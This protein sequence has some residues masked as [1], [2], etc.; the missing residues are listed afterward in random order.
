MLGAIGGPESQ[1]MVVGVGEGAAATDG[2]EPRIAL[3]REDHGCCLSLRCGDRLEYRDF[4]VWEPESA[5]PEA[6]DEEAGE[7]STDHLSRG[8]C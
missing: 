7:R 2:D 1:E 5:C 3:F 6:I 4:N 8:W